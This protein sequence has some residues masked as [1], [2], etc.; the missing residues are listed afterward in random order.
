MFKPLFCGLFAAMA[1]TVSAQDSF[2]LVEQV[3]ANPDN[4]PAPVHPIPHPRQVKW[5]ETEFY[6]FFHY[7][8]NTF[9]NLE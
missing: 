3:P 9:T 8:M 7:G 1:L 6:G 2:G 4:E 5:M